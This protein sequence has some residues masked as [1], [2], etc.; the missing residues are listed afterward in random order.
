MK[1]GIFDIHGDSACYWPGRLSI[2]EVP[3]E[4]LVKS[5]IIIYIMLW[6]TYNSRVLDEDWTHRFSELWVILFSG[7]VSI[8]KDNNYKQCKISWGTGI[9]DMKAS[10]SCE[11]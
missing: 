6:I 4:M 11:D 8:I 2:E 5:M 10:Y 3:V 9:I 7:G 1:L